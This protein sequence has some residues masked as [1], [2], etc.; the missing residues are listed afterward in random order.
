[1][2][3][4]KLMNEY[5]HGVVWVYEDGIVS[6]YDLIDDDPIIKRLNEET[7]ELYSACFE[8]DSHDQA[9]YFNKDLQKE[10]KDKMLNL[11]EQIIQRLNEIN[12]GSFVIEE[13]LV[14]KEYN[15]L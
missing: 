12:D 6:S 14:T 2:Y 5:L 10:T 7:E 8:F 1:M 4:I 13:D 11:V 9:C 3:S 15:K